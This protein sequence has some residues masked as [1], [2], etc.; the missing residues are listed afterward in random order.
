M[1]SSWTRDRTHVPNIGR[2]ILIHCTIREV[3]ESG[4]EPSLNPGFVTLNPWFISPYCINFNHVHE[5]C[6]ILL[7]IHSG[8][9][10]RVPVSCQVL[11]QGWG[12][13]ICDILK[14][15]IFKENC[16]YDSNIFFYCQNFQKYRNQRGKKPPIIHLLP[17]KPL[18]QIL[19]NIPLFFSAYVK[20]LYKNSYHTRHA[21]FNLLLFI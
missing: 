12:M 4:F 7:F 21:V 14:N 11:S 10:F 5:L 8:N 18:R 20:W 6:E 9:S 3:Q 16:N 15:C 19:E 2:W 13:T 1:E 17:G